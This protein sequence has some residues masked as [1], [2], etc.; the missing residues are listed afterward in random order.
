MVPGRKVTDDERI[1]KAQAYIANATSTALK[2]IQQSVAQSGDIY[3]DECGDEI[4]ADRRIALPSARTCIDCQE[5]L[6]R[7]GKQYAT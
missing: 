1:E 7:R 3:C 6:E 2:S 4:E 5:R